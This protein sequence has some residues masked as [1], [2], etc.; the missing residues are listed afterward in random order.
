MTVRFALVQ[1]RTPAEPRL[2]LGLS[3]GGRVHALDGVLGQ[4]TLMGLLDVWQQHMDAVR[5]LDPA[6]LPVVADA[7]LGTPL[8]F[9]RKVFCAG[10]NYYGHAEEMNTARPDP[11][12]EPFFFLKPPTTTVI[13]PHDDIRVDADAG[14]DLDWEAELAVVIGT[15]GKD[16]PAE[17]ALDHVAGYMVANDLSA[18][19]R[20][21][22]PEAGFP[23]FAWDWVSHKSM[24]GACPLGPGLVPAWDIPEPGRLDVRLDVNGAVK[25]DANTDDMVV[26]VPNLIAAASRISTLEPGDVILTGTPAGVG[27]PRRDFLR[28]GDV[29]TVTIEGLGSISNTIVEATSPGAVDVDRVAVGQPA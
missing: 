5:S 20:F 26:D 29:V 11:A 6:S 1:Y 10:A 15:G 21:A 14:L 3:A 22:R 4:D 9:P 12:A 19:G 23:A 27:M 8:T 28:I 17:R 16:I 25:Q 24:D 7:E 2:R 13:G 18:R